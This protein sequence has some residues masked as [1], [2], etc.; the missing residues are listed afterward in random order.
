[1]S[2]QISAVW[3]IFLSIPMVAA[4]LIGGA[5]SDRLEHTG[6]DRAGRILF[7][8]GAAIMATIAAYAA[9]K[10]ESVFANVRS[11]RGISTDALADV[12][13]LAWHRPVYPA[14]LIW[15]LWNFAPGSATPLQ[16][17]LQNALH[18]T[19]AEWGKGDRLF[20]SPFFVL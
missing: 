13:R 14:L 11:E 16:Y 10:P 8:V 15:L 2:G 9:W 5:L 7:L 6:A 3:N 18:A 17:H 4:L 1:M 12:R 19:D 20:F